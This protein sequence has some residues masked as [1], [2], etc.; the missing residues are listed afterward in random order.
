MTEQE[1]S[2]ANSLFELLSVIHMIAMLNLS[3]ANRLMIPKD[4]SGS[5]I[6]VVSSGSHSYPQ[7]SMFSLELFRGSSF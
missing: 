6:R 4:R 1:N 5:G 2:V 3:E 7:R